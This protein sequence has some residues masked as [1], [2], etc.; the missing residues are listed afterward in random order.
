MSDL[1]AYRT[2]VVDISQKA[3]AA[4]DAKDYEQAY[5]HYKEALQIWIHLIK[6][7]YFF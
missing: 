5:Y 4:D 7:K 3:K 2:K 6:C 1:S